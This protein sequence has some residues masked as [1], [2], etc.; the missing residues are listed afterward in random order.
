M[1]EILTKEIIPINSLY[2]PECGK[3]LRTKKC[4]C[5]DCNVAGVYSGAFFI[6][7][8]VL[9]LFPF[10]LIMCMR[11]QIFG[12]II[13]MSFFGFGIVRVVSRILVKM[14]IKRKDACAD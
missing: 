4:L 13:S 3:G 12:L 8:G 7:I 5:P 14:K 1:K 9:I 2:C 11:A 6:I 10:S